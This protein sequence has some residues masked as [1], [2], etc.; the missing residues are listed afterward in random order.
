[1]R[2]S[3]WPRPGAGISAVGLGVLLWLGGGG[4]ARAERNGEPAF[5]SRL[6]LGTGFGATDDRDGLRLAFTPRVAVELRVANGWRLDAR[7]MVPLLSS[8]S[9]NIVDRRTGES[10]SDTV[11]RTGN[12]TVWL[13]RALLRE[14]S[15][16]DFDFALG[17]ALPMASIQKPTP[18][19]GPDFERAPHTEATYRRALATEGFR[20]PWLLFWSTASA[21]AQGYVRQESGV[22]ITDLELTLGLLLP[23]GRLR[24]DVGFLGTISAYTG[25]RV[26]PVLELGMRTDLGYTTEQRD[27]FDRSL[28]IEGVQWSFAPELLFR[29]GGV[30]LT[31]AAT[32]GA[33]VA[34]EPFPDR[35]N[36]GLRLEVATAF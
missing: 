20:R 17:F 13:R 34:I 18:E 15:G 30:S 27:D 28:Q 3:R 10:R 7:W 11:P 31:A 9:G 19:T 32:V 35:A 8:P 16:F 25:V 33:G 36:W 23:A 2:V 24:K 12:P 6:L 22:V 26:L 14:P 1:M 4:D 21:L 5:R 29:F